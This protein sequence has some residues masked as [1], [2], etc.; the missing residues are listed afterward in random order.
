LVTLSPLT[1]VPLVLPRSSTTNCGPSRAIRAWW[2][3]TAELSI[4]MVLSGR[5]PMVTAAVCD[6]AVSFNTRPS[7]KSTSFGMD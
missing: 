3:E 1:N 5:R 6:T 4:T 2:D 7:N